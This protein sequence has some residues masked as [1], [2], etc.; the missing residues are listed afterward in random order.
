MVRKY[1]VQC[2]EYSYSAASDREWIC[3]ICG[4]DLTGEQIL[5]IREESDKDDLGES[6]KD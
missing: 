2:K 5:N 1:C 6:R 3:P 4:Y